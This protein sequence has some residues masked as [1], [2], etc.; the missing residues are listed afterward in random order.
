M[1]LFSTNRKDKYL[2]SFSIEKHQKYHEQLKP[3]T[4]LMH[5][6]SD[7]LFPE[8]TVRLCQGIADY[9]KFTFC[10]KPLPVLPQKKSVNE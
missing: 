7:Y 9:F 3:L 10:N 4:L 2:G 8:Q 6:L 5:L 1:V